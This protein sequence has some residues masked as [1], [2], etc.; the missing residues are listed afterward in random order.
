MKI[1]WNNRDIVILDIK[2]LGDCRVRCGD[3]RLLLIG[4]DLKFEVFA[5]DLN[6]LRLIDAPSCDIVRCEKQPATCSAVFEKYPCITSPFGWNKDSFGRGKW[7]KYPNPDHA[8]YA[9]IAECEIRLNNKIAFKA[10]VHTSDTSPAL[11]KEA[12]KECEI[13][14]LSTIAEPEKASQAVTRR[15][16]NSRMNG[17]GGGR[18]SH[19]GDDKIDAAVAGVR[20]R[21]KNNRAIGMKRACELECKDNDLEIKWQALRNHVKNPKRGRVIN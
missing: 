1:K 17:Q 3:F 13:R 7:A 12:A 11:R 6:A 15:A 10:L 5:K 20:A 4:A 21:I 14:K 9:D 16:R 19:D 8:F 2:R 18:P